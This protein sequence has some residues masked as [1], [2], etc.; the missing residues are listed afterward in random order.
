MKVGGNHKRLGFWEV[1][2]KKIVK[3]LGRWKEIFFV[4]GRESL[5]Y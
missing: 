3:R 1:V 4:D 5:F 2:F